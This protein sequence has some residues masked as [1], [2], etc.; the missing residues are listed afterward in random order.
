MFHCGELFRTLPHFF[1]RWGGSCKPLLLKAEEGIEPATSS[2]GIWV[3]NSSTMVRFPPEICVSTPQ[4]QRIFVDESLDRGDRILKQNG[5][6]RSRM[7]PL[8]SR[9]SPSMGTDTG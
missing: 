9:T 7:R 5:S 4:R 2:L 1:R 6:N 3:H 8:G